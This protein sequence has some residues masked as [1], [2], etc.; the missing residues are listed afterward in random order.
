MYHFEQ[1]GL[2]WESREKIQ[3]PFPS[4]C[5]AVYHSFTLLSLA[6]YPH[7]YKDANF[8]YIST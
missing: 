2:K 1:G 6:P 7:I 3:V 8:I 4:V 5:Y